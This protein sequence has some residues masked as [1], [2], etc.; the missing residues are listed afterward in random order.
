MDHETEFDKQIDKV[1]YFLRTLVEKNIDQFWFEWLEWVTITAAI[2]AVG[3]K[4]GSIIVTVVAFFSAALL[5]FKA[6]ITC[7]RVLAKHIWSITHHISNKNRPIL[8]WFFILVIASIPFAV[9]FFLG[10]VFTSLIS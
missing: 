1:H 10:E 3:R 5:F 9:V 7:E 8:F 2:W 6:W 4:S